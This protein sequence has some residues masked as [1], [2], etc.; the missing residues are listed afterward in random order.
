MI[1]YEKE[2]E[3]LNEQLNVVEKAVKVKFPTLKLSN[4][5]SK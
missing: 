5:L 1:K 2:L 4:Q 3:L